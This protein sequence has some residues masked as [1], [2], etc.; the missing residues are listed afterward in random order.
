MKNVLIV[1]KDESAYDIKPNIV[2][3]NGSTIVLGGVFVEFD[4]STHSGRIYNADKYLP[5]IETKENNG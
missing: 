5:R 4:K 3:K 2:H 1:E